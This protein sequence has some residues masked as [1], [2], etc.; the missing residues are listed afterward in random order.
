MKATD[1]RTK[2]D[3]ELKQQLSA[4]EAHLAKIREQL[5]MTDE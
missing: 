3:D 5:Q 4:I 2:S 1:L